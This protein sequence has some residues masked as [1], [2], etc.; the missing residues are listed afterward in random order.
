M[1][2]RTFETLNAMRGIA[3]IGVVLFHGRSLWHGAVAPHGYLAVDIFFML[4]GF[5]IAHAYEGRLRGG[6]RVAEFAKIRIIRFYPLYGLG[7]ALGIARYLMLKAG[8]NPD[9]LPTVDLVMATLTGLAFLPCPLPSHGYDLFILNPPSWSLFYELAVNVAFAAMAP[10]LSKVMLGAIVAV[11]GI[12]LLPLVLAAGNA[13]LGANGLDIG[14]GVARTVFSFGLGVLIYRSAPKIPTI[15]P[16]LV[17]LAVALVVGLPVASPYYDLACILLVSPLLL[18]AGAS[19]E[20]PVLL[21]RAF[22]YLGLISFPLYAVHRPLLALAPNVAHVLHLSQPVA[23]SLIV[24]GLLALCPL[25]D[26]FYDAPLR[27]WLSRRF[28]ERLARDP[29]EAAA[30]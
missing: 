13:D 25:L 28:K 5:V 3:A 16:L 30:P 18:M 22:I 17:L 10:R 21:H 14:A 12:C 26:R 24:I 1:A 29:A 8:H 11:S 9:A 6:L 27:R 20:P 2:R 4:S 15:P 19:S 23:G 7:L